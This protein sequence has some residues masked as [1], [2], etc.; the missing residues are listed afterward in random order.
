M[1]SFRSLTTPKKLLTQ[2]N[3]VGGSSKE[4]KEQGTALTIMHV[5]AEETQSNNNSVFVGRFARIRARLDHSYHD[6]YSSD[7]QHLQDEIILAFLTKA[8]PT[9]T[10]EPWAIY[11]AGAMGVG[12]TFV[13]N[14]L[15]KFGLLCLD[16]FVYV[17]PDALRECIPE[18]ACYIQE[19]A[20]TAG[21]MTQKE[22]GLMAEI[23]TH[24]ALEC[25]MS[26]IVDGSLRDSAWYE[27][28]YRE[29]RKQ[30]PKICL[31][32]FLIS[33]PLQDIYH[34]VTVCFVT[35]CIGSH[36]CVRS[37]T[38]LTNNNTP[39]T[40]ERATVTGR[41]IPEHV[42]EDSIRRVPLSV[43]KLR[44]SVDVLVEIYNASNTG[45]EILRIET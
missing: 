30:F 3:T 44:K 24:A 39:P 28:H 16:D 18:H 41:H 15:Q 43:A 40:Q 21:F 19:N 14:Q 8:R 22:A 42:L 20:K 26:I 37:P 45:V 29:L 7:R 2:P 1:C 27:K 4:Q 6:M 13:M 33:A 35:L 10:E 38:S 36:D 12:K 32:I 9:T 23:L 11:T 25:G 34:R 5:D 17:D 31:A